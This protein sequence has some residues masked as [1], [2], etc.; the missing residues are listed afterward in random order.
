MRFV[1]GLEIRLRRL[2]VFGGWSMAGA[3][4]SGRVVSPGGVGA[5]VECADDFGMQREYD[6]CGRQSR[7]IVYE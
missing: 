1:G 3:D 7:C 4:V 6:G 5:S 2:V